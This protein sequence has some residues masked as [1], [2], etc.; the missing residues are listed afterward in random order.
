[1]EID[2]EFAFRT[3]SE[4]LRHIIFVIWHEEYSYNLITW[5]PESRFIQSPDWYMSNIKMVKSIRI[6]DN[7]SVI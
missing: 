4:I 6:P 5:H 7:K 2:I 1:M 3:F